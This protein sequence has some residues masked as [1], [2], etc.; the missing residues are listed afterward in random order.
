MGAWGLTRS[1]TEW[2]LDDGAH[3]IVIVPANEVRVLAGF[4]ASTAVRRLSGTATTLAPEAMRL[5]ESLSIPMPGFGRPD[6][7]DIQ[8]ILQALADALDSGGL[9]A[10]EVSACSPITEAEIQMLEERRRKRSIPAPPTGRLLPS[11]RSPCTNTSC[12]WWMTRVLPC[13]ESS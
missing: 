11:P 12:G 7:E 2:H 5:A 1:G 3:K 8:R 10:L 9:V 6:P 4:E 13:R